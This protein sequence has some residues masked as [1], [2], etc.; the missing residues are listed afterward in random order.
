MRT[1]ADG[2]VN[3]SSGNFV[4]SLE[5]KVGIDKNGLEVAAPVDSDCGLPTEF[6]EPTE[7]VEME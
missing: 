4:F 5:L 3:N 7:S 6:T 1:Q 2:F